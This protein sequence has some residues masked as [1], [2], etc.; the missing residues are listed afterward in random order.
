MPKTSIHCA[1]KRGAVGQTCLPALSMVQMAMM[2][3]ILPF[4]SSPAEC[5]PAA[6]QCKLGD[7]VTPYCE[8]T[9]W[10]RPQTRTCTSALRIPF[11]GSGPL[12]VTNFSH[13]VSTALT[14]R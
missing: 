3:D 1:A 11:E 5:H 6:H 2:E 7:M 10:C 14:C 9:Q 12:S 13:A 4:T 8:Y